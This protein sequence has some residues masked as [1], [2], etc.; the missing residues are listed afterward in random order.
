MKAFTFAGSHGRAH[1][2]ALN[3]LYRVECG[4]YCDWYADECV[5]TRVAISLAF[6]G[7]QPSGVVGLVAKSR[8]AQ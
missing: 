6:K 8:R 2:D 5:A 7:R 4:G 3:G 1:V